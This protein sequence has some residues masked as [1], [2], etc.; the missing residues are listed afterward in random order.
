M[1][2]SCTI[3]RTLS[4][5]SFSVLNEQLPRSI[6]NLLHSVNGIA[7]QIYDHLLKLYAVAVD[8]WKIIR[9]VCLQN[10]PAPAQFTRRERNYLARCLIQIDDFGD[11]VLPLKEGS[12]ARDRHR[13]PDF[14]RELSGSAVSRAPSI[15]GGLSSNICRHVSALVIMPASGWLTSCAMEAVRIP[16]LMTLAMWASSDRDFVRASSESMRCVTSCTA[17]MY[18]NRP[19][20]S[21]V[22]RAITCRNLIR[23][24]G[25][26]ILWVCS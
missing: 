8:W 18:S 21:R 13:R 17:P 2:L 23:P 19:S 16:R 25:I 1:P 6:F 10:H 15:S 7:K 12:Q 5:P 14:R 20:G 3:S 4:P 26:T 11:K 24:S 9:E 22:A